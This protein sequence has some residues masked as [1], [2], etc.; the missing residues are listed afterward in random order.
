MGNVFYAI[1]TKLWPFETLDSHTLQSRVLQGERPAIPAEIRNSTDPFQQAMITAIEM[2]WI[3]NPD[4]R[5]TARQVEKY[6]ASELIRLGA[7]GEKRSR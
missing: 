4:Q 6:I 7:H 1:L 5:A 3:H 2:C